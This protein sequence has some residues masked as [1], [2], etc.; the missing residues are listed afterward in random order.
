LNYQVNPGGGAL[1]NFGC[2]AVLSI[3]RTRRRQ[4]RMLAQPFF[5][6]AARA[7]IKI[8]YPNSLD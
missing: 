2:E 1:S 5:E 6:I 4:N 3:S 8:G 7:E